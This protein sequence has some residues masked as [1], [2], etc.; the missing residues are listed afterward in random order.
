MKTITAITLMLSLIF[1]VRSP[2]LADDSDLFGAN[3][4]PNVMLLIDS[5]GSMKSSITS[6]IYTSATTYKGTYSSTVVYRGTTNDY[7]LYKSTVDEVTNSSAR[8]SL[9]TVGF[10]V[11]QIGG[12]TV[13]LFLGNYLNYRD[14]KTCSVS[15]R[16]IDIARRVYSNIVK[17]VEGVRFGVMRLRKKG[18]EIVAPHWDRQGDDGRRDR[19]YG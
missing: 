1:L 11:G 17:N 19:E 18:G 10:W 7:T 12:S 9:S 3:I 2:A 5:S 4:E 16:K 13:S 8:N 14:C 6:S 15:E